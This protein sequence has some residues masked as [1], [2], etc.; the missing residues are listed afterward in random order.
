[1]VTMMKILTSNDPAVM[2][3]ELESHSPMMKREDYKRV[4]HM[5]K[6]ALTAYLQ[7]IY[8]RGYEAGLEAARA[9]KPPEAVKA[10]ETIEN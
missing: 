4:K 2:P 1:M 9:A 5:D 10:D 3:Y 8:M 6:R 7:R